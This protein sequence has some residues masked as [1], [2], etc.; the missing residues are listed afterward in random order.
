MKACIG[1]TADWIGRL[2]ARAR[3]KIGHPFQVT[4]KPFGFV[5]AY[6]AR[7]AGTRRRGSSRRF[8]YASIDDA[9]GGVMRV[10]VS[11]ASRLA[12][13]RQLTT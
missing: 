10:A 7:T 12:D 11:S 4:R 13:L 8:R 3:A 5:T 1:T 2:K 6:D 9:A